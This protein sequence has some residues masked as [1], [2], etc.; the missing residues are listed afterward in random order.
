MLDAF[1]QAAQALEQ[2]LSATG[3][4]YRLLEVSSSRQCRVQFTGT[5]NHKHVVWD[6]C[7]RTLWDYANDIK[8]ASNLSEIELKQFI[9]IEQGEACYRAL[10]ILKLDEINTAAIGRTII[11]IRKY[12]RLHLGRHEYGD[13]VKF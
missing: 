1:E 8:Q 12:K 2:S 7:I 13:P 6:V 9:E 5:F 3:E 11:M 4:E 10:V